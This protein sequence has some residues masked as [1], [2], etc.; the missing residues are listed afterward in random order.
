LLVWLAADEQK[1]PFVHCVAFGIS[2]L[3]ADFQLI[4]LNVRIADRVSFHCIKT[5]GRFLS[6]EQLR[7]NWDGYSRR[8]TR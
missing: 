3:E 7:K 8:I 2:G 6:L 1:Q 4:P 5:N